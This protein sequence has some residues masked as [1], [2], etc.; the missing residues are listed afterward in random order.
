MS[1]AR[2]TTPLPRV[3][4]WLLVALE[5]LLLLHYLCSEIRA[6]RASQ[7]GPGGRAGNRNPVACH[8]YPA[9]PRGLGSR[10]LRSQAKANRPNLSRPQEKGGQIIPPRP[11][12]L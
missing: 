7:E 10:D 5:L 9:P 3:K 1:L 12:T 11:P 2:T 6:A 4:G 8:L